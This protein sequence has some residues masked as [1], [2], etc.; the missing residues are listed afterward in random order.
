[1]RPFRPISYG[2]WS[3]QMIINGFHNETTTLSYCSRSILHSFKMMW[4]RMVHNR[5]KKFS[6]D[7]SC[8]QAYQVLFHFYWPS[9]LQP[10]QSKCTVVGKSWSD[11]QLTLSTISANAY[12]KEETAWAKKADH[13]VESTKYW[14]WRNCSW[15]NI[16][17][18]E[19]YKPSK[20][21]NT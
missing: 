11:R 7:I 5:K 15:R 19:I 13:L 10:T 17:E 20:V 9:M 6:Y 2:G 14:N 4:T 16:I 12:S 21:K 3:M 8:F 1:M 18:M